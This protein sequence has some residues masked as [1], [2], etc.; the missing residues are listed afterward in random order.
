ME[1]QAKL[2]LL[3]SYDVRPEKGSLLH[4]GKFLFFVLNESPKIMLVL[5]AEGPTQGRVN[6][7]PLLGANKC[8]GEGIW[9]SI[10]WMTLFEVESNLLH[11]IDF[12]LK[13]LSIKSE[14]M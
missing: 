2:G 6:V 13:M 7:I 14:G 10:L 5:T 11:M 9:G 1:N 8:V 4:P 12:Y 3:F